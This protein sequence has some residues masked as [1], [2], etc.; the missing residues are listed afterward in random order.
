MCFSDKSLPYSN[1]L[2][3]IGNHVTVRSFAIICIHT[4]SC[5]HCLC[6]T[7][8]CHFSLKQPWFE[9]WA[10]LCKVNIKKLWNPRKFMLLEFYFKKLLMKLKLMP[11]SSHQKLCHTL[12]G[13]RYCMYIIIENCKT[14]DL[15]TM[16]KSHNLRDGASKNTC[17][18]GV[19]W[20]ETS[21]FSQ[22]ETRS[23]LDRLILGTRD[24]LW[25]LIYIV[26]RKHPQKHDF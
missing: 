6:F 17:P 4:Y 12:H 19:H 20:R 25:R 26:L 1:Q 9:Q 23:D 14:C 18:W 5:K 22:F 11:K 21:K 10:K 8:D 16:K 3:P 15:G 24:L 7:S 2:G 13:T